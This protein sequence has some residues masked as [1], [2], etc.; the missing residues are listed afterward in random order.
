LRPARF[1]ELRNG[2]WSRLESIVEKAQKKGVA[3]LTESEL[4]EITRLYPTVTVD[5]AR[6]RMYGMDAATMRRLNQLAIGAHGIL[7]R[8]K[9]GRPLSALGRFLAY[10]YPR[11]F[12]RLKAYFLVAF[13]LFAVSTLGAYASVRANPSNAYL[14]VPRG[15]DV[16][17]EGE[18]TAADVGERY[19]EVP[20]SYMASRI[21]TN[22]I[23]VAF[24][25]FSLGITAGIGTSYVLIFNSMMLGGFFAHFANHGLLR[26]CYEFLVPHGALEVFAI[27][28]AGA[29]G[30][31]IGLSIALPGQTTR[32]ASLR[33]G[34][35]EGVL[36]VLGTIP[37]FVVAGVIESY[38][39]P[40]YM[41]GNIKILIGLAALGVTL[42]YLLFAGLGT[43]SDVPSNGVNSKVVSSP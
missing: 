19:R 18:V 24:S 3:R 26:V 33:K 42:M 15:L 25:A 28:V 35:K 21:T 9:R 1:L 7:Y 41:S 14:F 27:I 11:L 40:S 17:N 37:M 32:M 12:R 10:E 30:L 8:R 39:T 4:H 2:V 29:A 23:Q 13:A 6:A 34:A 38:V 43:R 22:N 16:E 31:R 20:G 5:V 36:L